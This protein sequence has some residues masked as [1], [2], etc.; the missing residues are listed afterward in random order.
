[1]RMAGLQTYRP[2][3]IPTRASS[4]PRASKWLRLVAVMVAA[5][6][7]GTATGRTPGAVANAP[8]RDR[9]PGTRISVKS[10]LDPCQGLATLTTVVPPRLR[11]EKAREWELS[12]TSAGVPPP[13]RPSAPR[14]SFSAQPDQASQAAARNK[15][16]VR[17]FRASIMDPQI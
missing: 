16:G 10:A 6:C 8:A 9:P 12:R 5:L 13:L 3:P 1:S 2:P 14:L 17:V 4:A 15:A 7:R 11:A